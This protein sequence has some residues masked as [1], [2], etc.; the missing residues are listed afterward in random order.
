MNKPNVIALG[1]FDGVHLGHA[2][3][4]QKT[5][6]RAQE[7]GAH[8]A[9]FTFDRSPREFVTGKSVPLLTT[10]DERAALITGLYAIER[11][12]VAPFDHAMM[13]MPWRDFLDHLLVGQYHAVHLVAGH[14]YRFGYRN[15]GTPELLRAYCAD[16]GL[17]CDIIDKVELDGITVSSTYIRTLVESGD[18]SRATAFL[19]HPYSL[20]GTV[21]HG[22]RIGTSRLFPTA[23]LLPDAAHIVPAH[24]VYA[25]RVHLSDGRV[26]PG[27]TN[28]GVRPTV[29]SSGKV[30]VETHL[31]G[32]SG[33]LYGRNIRV[34]FLAYL[35]PEQK[36]PSTPALHDQIERDI[37]AA[38]ALLRA[39][40]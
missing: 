21:A 17:G 5:V 26:Y 13:T 14:D 7:L 12:I 30:T 35:R 15:E 16:H 8:S 28:V 24:G 6:Q 40:G 27:V 3:L 31:A 4:L 10:A 18:M 33:D 32:F 20:G 39:P 36:F 25:T 1:F 34:D 2:A 22:Q 37:A 29:S 23:N 11:V 9:A 19:G 38:C